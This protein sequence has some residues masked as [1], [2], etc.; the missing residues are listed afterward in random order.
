MRKSARQQTKANLKNGT[1]DQVEDLTDELLELLER[2]TEEVE[3]RIQSLV[4]N[5][6]VLAETAALLQSVPGIGLVAC[7]MLIAEMPIMFQ[8]FCKMFSL[9]TGH[10]KSFGFGI[11]HPLNRKGRHHDRDA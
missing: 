8:K 1:A 4:A 10:G 3:G 9:R 5:D 7:A 11:N 6:A 2:R